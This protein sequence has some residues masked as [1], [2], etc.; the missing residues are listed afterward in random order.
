MFPAVESCGFSYEEIMNED[1]T[2]IRGRNEI[3]NLI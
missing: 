3:G 2:L 1:L